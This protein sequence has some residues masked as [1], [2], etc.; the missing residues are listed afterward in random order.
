MK[1]AWILRSQS[2]I[3]QEL[4]EECEPADKWRV[5]KLHLDNK[6]FSR[7]R[8]TKNSISSVQDKLMDSVTNAL[9]QT[10]EKAKALIK[11]GEL[12]FH[13]VSMIVLLC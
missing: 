5:K 10:P 8:V 3:E 9:E 12:T 7:R 1:Q 11:E 4:S 2:A 6:L 13:S